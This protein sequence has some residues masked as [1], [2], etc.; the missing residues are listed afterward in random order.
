M[1]GNMCTFKIPFVVRVL[2]FEDYRHPNVVTVQPRSQE[3]MQEAAR[4]HHPGPAEW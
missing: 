4:P 3:A 2:A 1:T